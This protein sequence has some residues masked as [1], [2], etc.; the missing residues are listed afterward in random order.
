MLCR[1]GSLSSA[2][3]TS[4]LGALHLSKTSPAHRMGHPC[5]S[6]RSLTS[7]QVR[8]MAASQL[9]SSCLASGA[10]RL[11]WTS[12]RQTATT[13]LCRRRGAEAVIAQPPSAVADDMRLLLLVVDHTSAAHAEPR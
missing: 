4:S 6:A 13:G 11:R 12:L 5:C 1:T 3:F 9:G 8:S 2:Q 10:V 7:C